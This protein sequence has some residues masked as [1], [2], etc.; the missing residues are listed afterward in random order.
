MPK[1]WTRLSRL[2]TCLVAYAT[3][4]ESRLSAQVSSYEGEATN[5]GTAVSPRAAITGR[6]TWLTQTDGNGMLMIFPPLGGS[7]PTRVR[8]WVDSVLIVSMNSGGDTIAWVGR[9][10][11]KAIRGAYVV[12]GG[13]FIHQIGRWQ[14][15]LVSGPALLVASRPSQGL[16]AILRAVRSV[17]MTPGQSSPI[18]PQ[19]PAERYS[20]PR[21]PTTLSPRP[22]IPYHPRSSCETGHWID[23]VLDDGAIIK[24]EDGS[25]WQVDEVDRVTTAIWLP[26]TDV[27]LCDDGRI[28]DTEDNE[29]VDVTR[30]P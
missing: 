20:P 3:A 4:V 30:I 6:I 16:A 13:P 17:S 8:R 29:S 21:K 9:V 1:F 12:T 22:P 7:G 24:L 15:N 10:D 28:I 5:L 18:A 27:I 14:V 25:L 19:A 26:M 2:L 23:S 11:G